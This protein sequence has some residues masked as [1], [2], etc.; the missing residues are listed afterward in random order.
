LVVRAS[1][2]KNLAPLKP[3]DL[4]NDVRRC[5]E[6][7]DADALRVTRF[8]QRTVADQ[9]RAQER[10]RL[11]IQITAWYWMAKAFVRNG[12]FRVA[13]VQR[14]SGE[15]RF[16]AKIF[17]TGAAELAL[18]TDPSQPWHADSITGGEAICIGAF[19]GDGA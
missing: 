13:S 14:V 19:F 10:S 3:S 5:A 16:P 2:G 7:I 1:K 15:P 9:P 8:D 4:C 17:P 18:S 12:E 11:S 6:A